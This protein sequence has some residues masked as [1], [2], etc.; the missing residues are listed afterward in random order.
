MYKNF[1][2][3]FILFLI[4]GWLSLIRREEF[5][6]VK[7]FF[8]FEKFVVFVKLSWCSLDYSFS[9]ISVGYFCLVVVVVLFW[10]VGVLVV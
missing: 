8:E 4:S 7:L 6:V 3:R 5:F 9:R 2:C 1:L 10:V